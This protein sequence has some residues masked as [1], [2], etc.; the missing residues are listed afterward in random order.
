M[1]ISFDQTHHIKTTII[2]KWFPKGKAEVI[3]TADTPYRT[4]AEYER[5]L[6]EFLPAQGPELEKLQLEHGGKFN[7]L[8]G[9]FLHVEQV[10]RP[11]LG[12]TVSRLAQFNVAPNAA[13]FQG[14]KRMARYLATHL[15]API[16][17]PAQNIKLYQRIRWEPEPGKVF[18]Q[19]IPNLLHQYIDSDH[20]RDIKT[21]KSISCVLTAIL[22]VLVDWYMGKQTCIA[23]HSTDA[24][25]R[26]FF[27][28]AMR[29]RF[30]RMI[31]DFL[32]MPM[33][34]PTKIFED[35]QPA[36]DIMSAGQITSRVKHMAVPVA[37]IHEDIKAG[38]VE[39][40]KIAGQINP[41]DIGTKPL[42][43]PTLHRHA[44]QCRGQRFYP[45]AGSEHGKLMDVAMVSQ[46]LTEL[47]AE[48]AGKV[49]LSLW[50]N[51]GVAYDEKDAAQTNKQQS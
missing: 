21:R 20:A 1:G 25:V 39:P 38:I 30:M 17:Y 35:N 47:E 16:M 36:I 43:A 41:S 44:R 13:S 11:E 34:G 5:S 28:A 18:E 50:E 31:V 48:A 40:V 2:E 19:M 8:I 15:H 26:A 49:D 9:Q 23:A 12:F 32:H 3:K 27:T 51:V 29:N 10:S 42:A 33:K 22:G 37:M 24:E 6:A 45:P 46:R 14:L 4:D 7:A